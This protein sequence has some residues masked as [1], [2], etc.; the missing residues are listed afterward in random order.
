MTF[1]WSIFG[2]PIFRA[3]AAVREIVAECHIESGSLGASLASRNN[4]GDHNNEEIRFTRF[5]EFVAIRIRSVAT[6]I[7]T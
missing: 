3:P 4:L 5:T 2:S 6:Q 1:Q 7:E